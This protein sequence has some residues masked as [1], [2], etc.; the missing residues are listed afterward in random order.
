MAAPGTPTGVKFDGIQAPNLNDVGQVT[1]G[2]ILGG[3]GVT[4]ANE[5]GIWS[6]SG[7]SLHLVARTGDIA[8]DSGGKRF[9]H[10]FIP[11]LNNLGETAFSANFQNASSGDGGIYVERGGVLE[12]V[13]R[14][15]TPAA[16]FPIGAT[17]DVTAAH[18][19]GDDGEVGYAAF[20][21]PETGGVTTADAH[22]VWGSSSGTQRLIARAGESAPGMPDNIVFNGFGTPIKA[23]NLLMFAASLR[24]D[25]G[26]PLD[27][28][29]LWIEKNGILEMAGLVPES[30]PGTNEETIF[31]GFNELRVNRSG[32]LS[33]SG[34]LTA[35]SPAPQEGNAIYS[36]VGGAFEMIA[37]EGDH[38]PGTPSGTRFRDLAQTRY[39]FSDSGQIAFLAGLVGGDVNPWLGRDIP[40]EFVNDHGIWGQDRSGKL[41]LI[42]RAGDF[43]D[44]DGGP[45]TDLRRISAL[46]FVGQYGI[47]VSGYEGLNSLG[48][49]AFSATFT[50]GSS[51]VFISDML[52]VP[53]PTALLIAYMATAVLFGCR[54]R[55]RKSELKS[56]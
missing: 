24:T 38:A 51:G 15:G 12:L 43:I 17:V 13:A 49:L 55:F 9:D 37:R 52:A 29:G 27:V 25:A 23:G 34:R 39:G 6:E 4:R 53:E 30:I 18:T 3:A 7:G 5:D 31:F 16:G 47:G 46:G 33:F 32:Q 1:F 48:Q 21:K 41:R 20:V 14:R 2:A 40:P 36:D 28:L 45:A 54:I 44:V 10:L 11:S 26:N 35:P 8:P 50:D 22:A 42:V 19:L 56:W